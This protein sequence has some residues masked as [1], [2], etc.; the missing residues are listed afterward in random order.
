MPIF[1]GSSPSASAEAYI[2]A[3]PLFLYPDWWINS[4]HA[5]LEAAAAR[6]VPEFPTAQI[7]ASRADALLVFDRVDELGAIRTPTMVLCA[8]DDYLTPPYFSRE[9]ASLIPGSDIVMLDKGGHACSQTMPDEFNAAVLRFL[10]VHEAG[11]MSG[12]Q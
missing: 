10:A 3:T 11:A 7:A 1:A 12:T 4:K 8:K 9:L 6:Q 5:E 2:A